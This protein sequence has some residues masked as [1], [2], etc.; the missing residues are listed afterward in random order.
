KERAHSKEEINENDYDIRRSSFRPS[1]D[2]FLTPSQ[3]GKTLNVSNSNVL[4]LLPIVTPQVPLNI[5][6]PVIMIKLRTTT[7]IKNPPLTTINLSPTESRPLL[8]LTKTNDQQQAQTIT[9]P[10]GHLFTNKQTNV[11]K[12][13]TYSYSL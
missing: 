10:N 2:H 6:R 3:Y 12:T 13:T 11:N 7:N 8:L 9:V 4:H 1:I 5:P